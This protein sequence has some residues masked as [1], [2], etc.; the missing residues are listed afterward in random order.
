MSIRMAMLTSIAVALAAAPVAGQAGGPSQPLV[1]P[2]YDAERGISLEQAI[3]QAVEREPMLRAARTDIEAARGLRQQADLRPNPTMSFERREEPGGTDH[4]TS[5]AVQWPLDLFR[6]PG[7]VAVAE[8]NLEVAQYAAGDRERVLAADVRMAYG[9]VLSAIRDLTVRD[10]LV[11]A[12]RRQ[13]DV[14]RARAEQGATPPLERDLLDVELRRLEAERFSLA[15]RADVAMVELKRLMGLGPAS[16]LT[17]GDSLENAV[18]RG[19]AASTAGAVDGRIDAVDDRSDVREAEMQTHLAAARIDS[20]RR[21]G[22]FDVTLVG[23]YMRMDAG[24]P[25][26]AF[27]PGGTLQRVRGLFNYA[28]VGAMVNVPLRNRNQ[29]A[30]A[31]AEAQRAGADARR[32]ALQ[33]AARAELAAAQAR[34]RNAKRAL[35]IYANGARQLARQNLDV[36][37]QTYELGRATVFDVLTE[38]RRFLDLERAYTDV[39]REAYEATTALK[40]A[41]GE[42]R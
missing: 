8:R 6:K 2:Y 9:Q 15:T 42:V 21:E 7:R 29:G 36:V 35:A 34:D 23:S 17:V 5:A 22:R 41:T 24:F 28:A 31:A 37:G 10:E 14:V 4:Q 19:E 40:R 27:A 1:A 11:A 25:Q 20:A 38:Q 3:T 16:P 33:L 18:L 12:T 30:I 32:E 26:L 39:L 13:H